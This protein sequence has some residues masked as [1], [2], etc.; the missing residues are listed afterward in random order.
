MSSTDRI[1]RLGG[2]MLRATAAAFLAMV[3]LLELFGARYPLGGLALLLPG[4]AAVVLV[5]VGE[6]RQPG[7]TLPVAVLSLSGTAA[8]AVWRWGSPTGAPEHTLT[9][10]IAETVA[11]WIVTM[12]TV[13]CWD[14][15]WGRAASV[16]VVL[17][18]LAYPTRVASWRSLI[19]TEA[20]MVMVVTAAVAVGVYLRSTDLRRRDALDQVRRGERLDLAR[21]L[22][23]FVAH[24][25]T[26]IVVQSQASAYVVSQDAARSVEAFGRIEAAGMQALTSMRRLV[27]VLRE[28]GAGGTRP[29]GDLEQVRELVDNFSLGDSYGSLYVSPDIADR[30]RLPPEVSA[31][32]Y[33]VVQEALTNVRKHAPASATVAVSV[34]PAADGVEVA[35]RDGGGEQ[36]RGRLSD[37]GG[38]FGLAGLSERLAALGGR[39]TAGPRPEGGWEVVA[40]LPLDPTEQEKT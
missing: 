24:H 29:L 11:L 27:S 5:A 39:F 15:R 2:F 23:D 10:G 22:H 37:S 26:G 20:L 12:W 21:D 18:L 34:T 32:L 6:R 3:L 31:T 25:I 33:R 36:R 14:L 8:L 9:P 16:A 40:W 17:A 30:R 35:V 7:W 13:R 19:V 28:D 1:H 38:G 4:A